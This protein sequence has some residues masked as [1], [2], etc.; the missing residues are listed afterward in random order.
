[1]NSKEFRAELV[2]IMPGYKWTVHK[3][4]TDGRLEGTGI[5]TSGF[6]RLSTLCIIRIER[7]DA[8]PYYEA[9]SAGYGKKAWWLHA[10]IGYTLAKALRNLQN[11]YEGESNKYREH[12]EALQRGRLDANGKQ[13]PV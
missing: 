2:K 4:D 9:K 13:E 10:S 1:M 12:A 3:S 6:N 5:Q 8:P 11:Y 7:D